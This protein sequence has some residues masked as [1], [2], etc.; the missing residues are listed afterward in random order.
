V[1]P[2]VVPS[3]AGLLL[4]RECWDDSVCAP[5]AETI[6]TS[7]AGGTRNRVRGQSPAENVVVAK[8]IMIL[9]NIR[10]TP[11]LIEPRKT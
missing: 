1:P 10:R 11:L 6:P 2:R 5:V 4:A 7:M 9:R 8:T 3:F